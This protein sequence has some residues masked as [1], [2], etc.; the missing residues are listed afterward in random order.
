MKVNGLA[1]FSFP[2]CPSQF[3]RVGLAW[4]YSRSQRTWGEAAPEDRELAFPFMRKN[5]EQKG[6]GGFRFCLTPSSKASN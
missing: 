4:V 3:L 5:L 6:E 1:F 2:S